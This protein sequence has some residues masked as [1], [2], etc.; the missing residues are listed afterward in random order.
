M[1]RGKQNKKRCAYRFHIVKLLLLW[2]VLVVMSASCSR[3]IAQAVTTQ[4]SVPA[5]I[6][7]T[8]KADTLTAAAL[9]DSLIGKW[10]IRKTEIAQVMN[11]MTT[12][13]SQAERDEMQHK[14]Q[15]YQNEFLSLTTTFSSDKTYQSTFNGQSDVGTW[16]VSRKMEIETISKVSGYAMSFQV[17]SL[18]Q[19]VLVTRYE[20]PDLVLLLT[21]V[22]Q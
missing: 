7:E 18:N 15:E 20:A 2:C 13:G 4:N 22:R 17:E 6:P 9:T 12:Y 10:K 16:R 1:L 3:H 8:G 19:G 5:A 14:Q 11:K 21:F